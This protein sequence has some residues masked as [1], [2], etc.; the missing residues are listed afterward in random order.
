VSHLSIRRQ[1]KR[2]IRDRFTNDPAATITES[3]GYG[4]KLF[5]KALVPDST[6]IDPFY[7]GS[8]NVRKA[9]AE[10]NPEIVEKVSRALD[11]ASAFIK[12]NQ[13][14]AK[15]IMASQD[16]LPEAFRPIVKDF[17]HSNFKKTNEVTNADLADMKDYY[18]SKK[19]LPID[20]NTDN[21]Q[22]NSN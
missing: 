22:Y 1:S 20:I 3:K 5:Q 8:F 9:Y 6:K 12:N 2:C 19:I 15:L 17:P 7:F 16:Y 10:E 21:L 4:K 18:L 11:Q 13:N 14:E